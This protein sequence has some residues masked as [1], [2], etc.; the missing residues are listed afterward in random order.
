LL[1][2]RG[3]QGKGKTMIAI[4][5]SKRLDNEHGMYYFCIAAD[6]QRNHAITILRG[7]LWQLVRRC[8]EVIPKLQ[9]WFTTKEHAAHTLSSAETLWNIL[10]VLASEPIQSTILFILDGLDKCDLDSRRWL[11]KKVVD[12]NK[13]D[14]A[15]QLRV[16]PISH[17]IP[18]LKSITQIDLDVSV[19]PGVGTDVEAF[20]TTSAQELSQQV[21][22]GKFSLE[23]VS[24]RLMERSKSTFLWISF[25]MA[26]LRE[27]HTEY[28]VVSLVHSEDRLPAGLT[29]MY[30]RL[31]R[32]ICPMRR[33][34]TISIFRWVAISA[35]P[36][37]LEELAFAVHCKPQCTVSVVDTIR[38]WIVLC[39]PLLYTNQSVRFVPE[40][41]RAYLTRTAA[42]QDPLMEQFRVRGEDAHFEAAQ[43][44]LRA[45]KSDNPLKEY[46]ETHWIH[47]AEQVRSRSRQLTCDSAQLTTLLHRAV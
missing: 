16:L 1:W 23:L 45:L 28:E 42:D 8:P 11:A 39:G 31:L 41:A 12:W 32:S 20:V 36:L 33:H 27:A 13:S 18:A 47:H 40:S 17:E 10:V 34:I 26:A 22:M 3:S 6:V 2:T 15:C 44:C 5:L 25:A 43:L 46:A 38:D 9:R 24:Q 37:T 19:T 30:E 21:A 4:F 29:S 14:D 35:V 7:V